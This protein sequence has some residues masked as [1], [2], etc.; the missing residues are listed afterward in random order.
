[1]QVY[2]KTYC[3]WCANHGANGVATSNFPLKAGALILD[4]N[5]ADLD[6]KS[7]S[8]TWRY[9]NK[10]TLER[11]FTIRSYSGIEVN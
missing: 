1:M 7:G 5:R 3:S 11:T 6:W 9:R 2:L 8:F 10:L 4:R